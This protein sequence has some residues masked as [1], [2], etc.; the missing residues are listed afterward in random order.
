M[1][2]GRGCS[3][4]FW[5]RL[6]EVAL[7]DHKTSITAETQ[8]AQRRNEFGEASMNKK[9]A[10]KNS[11]TRGAGERKMTVKEMLEFGKRFRKLVKG[12]VIDHAELLYDERG[13]PK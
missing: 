4:I 1:W 6:G 5:G 2:R 9:K 7:L 8:R 3:G 13:L 10:T 11:K 12:P